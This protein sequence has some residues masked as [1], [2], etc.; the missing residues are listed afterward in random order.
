MTGTHWDARLYDG[1]HA[2]VWQQG[3]ALLELLG[4]KPGERVLDLGCGTGHL[5][6]QVA[7]AGAK[8]VGLDLAPTM[9]EEARRTYPQLCFVQ[10][11]ARDFAFDEPFDAVLS[12]AALHWV[13]PPEKVIACVSRALKPG[14]RFVAE[15]GGRGNVQRIA[16]ALAGAA[17]A[18]GPGE[19]RS[20]WYFP[21][22][23]EYATLLEAGGLEVTFAVLFDR[24]TPLQGDEGMRH[25]VAMFAGGLLDA[26]PADRREAFLT[27]VE[28]RLRP[29]LYRDGG[30]FA[31][32]RRL[33]VV[34]SKTGRG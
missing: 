21:A 1:R 11:D 5:T 33:R 16:A 32:Y 14:G 10:G 12:N 31:D 24:P 9:I 23:A 18:I 22:I 28:S 15:F 27:L 19:W 13:K 3:A 17:A 30:W 34:A 20:P 8:V 2:F 29:T 7:A 26:V 6:A 4:P 25:W